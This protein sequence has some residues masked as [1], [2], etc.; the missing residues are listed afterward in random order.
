MSNRRRPQRTVRTSD[1]SRAAQPPP[2]EPAPTRTC[3]YAL[4]I[5]TI[6]C[7]VFVTYA[8]SLRA[9]FILDDQIK[10]ERNPDIRSLRGIP[11]T[12]IFRY[13]PHRRSYDRNDPSRP[14]TY[15]SFMLNYHFG[16]LNTF[17]WHLVNTLLHLCNS[18]L[19]FFIAAS[20][21]RSAGASHA[22]HAAMFGALFFA[23]HP[24]NAA[25]VS[26]IFSRSDLL[27][28]MF[29]LL[30]I[31]AFMR[32][33]RGHS[34]VG[35]ATATIC[36]VLALASKQSAV[37]FPA[38][39]GILDLLHPA[40]DPDSRRSV[41][42]MAAHLAQW[43]VFVGYIAFRL[44]YLGGVGDLEAVRTVSPAAYALSQPYAVLRYLQMIAIPVGLSID[45]QIAMPVSA[46]DLRVMAGSGVILAVAVSAYLLW[47]RRRHP[48]SRA[49]LFALVWL[50]LSLSPTSSIF[51]TTSAIVENRLYLAGL[52][53]AFAAAMAVS[54]LTRL[55]E[56]RG[57]TSSRWV[58]TATPVV[59]VAILAGLGWGLY[60]RNMLFRE[61]LRLWLD[62]LAQY[63]NHSRAHNTVA[64]IYFEQMGKTAEA[65]HHFQEAVRLNPGNAEAHNNIANIHY[66]N[67]RYAEA[68]ESY[69]RSI[70]ADPN[71]TGARKNLAVTYYV[72]GNVELAIEQ[73]LAAREINPRDPE[74]RFKLAY[75]YRKKGYT[76]LARTELQV[77]VQLDPGK[78]EYREALASLQ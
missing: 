65:L 33:L 72:T 19:I 34:T 37:V 70:A 7:A 40:R 48:V 29:V 13:D 16:G 44:L 59:L 23:L 32:G 31:G 1:T 45:H 66:L 51:P 28:T 9:P 52:G 6:V 17:G 15:F 42:P 11:G 46:A 38:L 63:P 22:T 60:R 64:T 36:H 47:Q 71:F 57:T 4:A 27:A 78:Q 68:V 18:V 50:F 53:I 25:A 69:R 62:V 14:L 26:Y 77:A 30:G 24:V 74:T 39:V 76:E 56:R 41:F 12:L 73:L 20:L 67:K 21:L 75:M 54:A 8:P 5:S 58:R 61:P 55:T 49:Y 10:I 3:W 2:P 35:Y 43:G